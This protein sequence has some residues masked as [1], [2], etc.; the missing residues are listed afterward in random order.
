MREVLYS[1]LIQFCVPV[2]IFRLIEMCLNGTYRKVLIG[3]I[4]LMQF[5]F[6]MT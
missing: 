2:R 4:C 6:R 1:N 3:K 5:L